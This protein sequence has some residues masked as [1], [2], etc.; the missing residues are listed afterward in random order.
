MKLKIFLLIIATILNLFSNIKAD[1]IE[2]NDGLDYINESNYFELLI[3]RDREI[4]I[5]NIRKFQN[6]FI[7]LNFEIFSLNLFL[8]NY[9][10]WFKLSL[11]DNSSID[12]YYISIPN[13][14]YF[15][16]ELYIVEE[17][18]IIPNQ[19]IKINDYTHELFDLTLVNYT[20]FLSKG[21][22]YTVYF[23]TNNLY[24]ILF[25]IKITSKININKKTMINQLTYGL[26]YGSLITLIIFNLFLLIIL[27]DNNIIYYIFY[28]SS[29]FFL[30]TES[31]GHSNI[32]KFSNNKFIILLIFL[33]MIFSLL[34][35]KSFLKTS[36]FS[37][38]LDKY[39]N[40]LILSILLSL[41]ICLFISSQ[42]ILLLLIFL[43]FL[44]L[45]SII[46]TG[47]YVRNKKFKPANF[48][49][50]AWILLSIGL[51]FKIINLFRIFDNNFISESLFL[52]SISLEKLLI[53][54]SLTDKFNL[55]RIENQNAITQT[56]LFKEQLNLELERKVKERTEKLNK[57]LNSLEKDLSLAKNIQENILPKNLSEYSKFIISSIYIPL[58]KVGGDFYD[59]FEVGPN[60]IRIFIAD[61]TGHG[62]QASMVTMSIKSEYDNLKDIILDP[63]ELIFE[64][65]KKFLIVYKNMN[66]YF[67]AFII[68]LDISNNICYY[69][70]AGH[71]TQ[72]LISNDTIIDLRRTGHILGFNSKN[73][74]TTESIPFNNFDKLFL[75]TDGL[76]EE[77]NIRNEL[78]GDEKLRE[79]LYLN[80]GKSC[81]ELSEICLKGLKDHLG[82]KD[83][84][85]DITI[86]TVEVKKND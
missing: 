82:N 10:Y 81:I 59:I 7:K 67:S 62:V 29:F 70:S 74:W 8:D 35:T 37:I 31:L 40:Y 65:Q 9:D 24:S 69:S 19:P 30:L 85:D 68:D 32:F 16:Y 51:F 73:L 21:K 5:N 53:T 45:I 34:F 63:S 61:A 36:I 26:I 48:F 38:I 28:I 71:P 12:T 1:T 76:Y 43:I 56:I 23:H 22:H 49:I 2:L 55:I 13:Y 78:F 66:I 33:T 18:T 3:D 47:L 42:L 80:R 79:I 84:Q 27:K 50:L 4:S 75:F 57:N 6:K 86:V 58:D 39:L 11:R 44:T 25:P 83:K 54:I 52:I 41:V 17:G 64:L 14:R 46:G 72:Y 77:F 15:N 60:K 20:P